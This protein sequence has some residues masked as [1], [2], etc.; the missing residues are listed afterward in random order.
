MDRA[1]RVGKW[2][3]KRTLEYE[4]AVKKTERLLEQVSQPQAEEK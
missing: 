1:L 3:K 4:R 2:K